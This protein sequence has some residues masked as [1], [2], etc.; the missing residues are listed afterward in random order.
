VRQPAHDECP[1]QAELEEQPKR[2]AVRGLQALQADLA[3]SAK[4]EAMA[5]ARETSPQ[6]T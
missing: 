2:L 3:L 6:T 1:R 5:A 4:V